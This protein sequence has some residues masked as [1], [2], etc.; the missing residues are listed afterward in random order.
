MANPF[1]ETVDE[2]YNP[3]AG[4]YDEPS[5]APA[6]PAPA[7]ATYSEPAPEAKPHRG[8]FGGAVT[9]AIASATNAKFTDP[10]TGMPV[11]ES[12]VEAR[13]RQ[14][15]E[16]ER[17]IAEKEDAMRNGTLQPAA[18]RKNFPPL[19]KWWE[20]HPDEDIPEHGRKMAKITFWLFVATGLVYLVN[21]I[22]CLACLGSKGAANTSVGLLIGLSIVYLLAFW[23]L[24]FEICYFVLYD[25]LR[26]SKGM[27]F[28]CGLAMY[29]IWWIML[30]FNVIGIQDG[31]AV[32]FIIMINLFGGGAS[33]VGAIA[34]IFS[35]L[36]LLD[37]VA[38]AWMFV[39]WCRW[40]KKEGLSR[41]AF[42]EAA[43]YAAEQAREN[44]DA[45][46]AVARSTYG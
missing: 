12:Q 14:L 27:K 20:Y 40:Y 10:V 44:P 17:Q 9:G 5:P 39:L 43:E 32:G 24:S 16:R 42:T 33:G 45:V 3:F 25:A 13:E 22:G 26:R 18:T 6:Q 38:L 28:I 7:P 8:G 11:T 41:K 35:I 23:P 15:A 34:C 21:A 1:D 37:A 4:G 2:S 29:C 46:A 19:L 31:G 30:V 36:G